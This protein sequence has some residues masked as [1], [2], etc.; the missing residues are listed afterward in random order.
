MYFFDLAMQPHK[1][2]WQDAARGMWYLQDFFDFFC[3]LQNFRVSEN[4]RL[5]PQ[6][7]FVHLDAA[8]TDKICI[9]SI[10]VSKQRT[11]CWCFAR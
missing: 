3:M 11:A 2:E 6:L 9:V 5:P 4:Q 10:R 8:M 1:V 7:A